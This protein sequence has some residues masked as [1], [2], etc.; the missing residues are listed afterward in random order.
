M[1]V[2]LQKF[3]YTINKNSYRKNTMKNNKRNSVNNRIGKVNKYPRRT[4][5]NEIQEQK[6]K[7][8]KCI[9]RVI[10]KKKKS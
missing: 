1:L 8:I 7:S 3:K 2:Y 6:I 10:L 9:T 4:K 5:H